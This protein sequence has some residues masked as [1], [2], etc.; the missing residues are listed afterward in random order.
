MSRPRCFFVCFLLLLAPLL[1]ATRYR[2]VVTPESTV[3]YQAA[4]SRDSWRGRA[5]VESLRLVFDDANLQSLELEI[6]LYPGEFDS[7]NFIRDANARRA[8]FETGAYPEIRFVATG[9]RADP[10]TLP[11]GVARTVGLEGTLTMHGVSRPLSLPVNVE[12]DETELRATGSFEVSLSDFEMTRPELFGVRV[13]DEVSVSFEVVG[14][15][16]SP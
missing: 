1:L 9:L 13:N 4:D 3:T 6:T 12:R 14:A 7:G 15:L 16:E 5:P 11:V 8:V 10:A 2:V